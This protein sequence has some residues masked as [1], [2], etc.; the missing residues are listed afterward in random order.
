[1]VPSMLSATKGPW[2]GPWDLT[3]EGCSPDM[4]AANNSVHI[5]LSPARGRMEHSIRVTRPRHWRVRQRLRD[6][7]APL[8]RS[9]FSPSARRGCFY[10]A[11]PVDIPDSE[12]R[13]KT[14]QT[15]VVGTNGRW[16]PRME[17]ILW[18]AKRAPKHHGPLWEL[19]C[20]R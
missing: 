17:S 18:H 7:A 14:R 19:A 10:P 5:P 20:L 9:V 1:M 8:G 15:K 4:P 2:N 3:V 13:R 6:M 16:S 12:N 11:T